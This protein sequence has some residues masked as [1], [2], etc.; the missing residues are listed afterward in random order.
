MTTER[1]ESRLKSN[2]FHQA[3]SLYLVATTTPTWMSLQFASGYMWYLLKDSNV[4]S[5]LKIGVKVNKQ[6]MNVFPCSWLGHFF[7]HEKP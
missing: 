2:I 5:K 3:S 7:T 1:N 6:S 4:A